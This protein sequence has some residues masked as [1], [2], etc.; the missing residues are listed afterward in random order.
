MDPRYKDLQ[1]A[2]YANDDELKRFRQLLV[3][4]V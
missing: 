3:S 2:I 1:R 4:Q